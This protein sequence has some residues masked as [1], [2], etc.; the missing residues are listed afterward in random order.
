MI[1]IDLGSVI[2]R[3]GERINNK[4]GTIESTMSIISNDNKIN[5]MVEINKVKDYMDLLLKGFFL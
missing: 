1:K 5:E 2:Q 4:E 3:N